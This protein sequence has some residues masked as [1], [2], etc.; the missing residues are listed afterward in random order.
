MTNSVD[1]TQLELDRIKNELETLKEISELVTSSIDFNKLLINIINTIARKMQTDICSVYLLDNDNS[2]VLEAT[3]G[4]NHEVVGKLKLKIGE[5]IIGYTAESGEPCMVARSEHHP[6]YVYCPETGE[7][8]DYSMLAVPLRREGLIMGVLCVQTYHERIYN[9]D[10]VNF[11]FTTA[12][13]ISG[14]I[15]NAQLF[16]NQK[17][18]LEEISHLYEVGN[19][20]SHSLELPTVLSQI[21]TICA[22]MVDARGSILQLKDRGHHYETLKYVHGTARNPEFK[23]V[24]E[25]ISPY[26][27]DV[28]HQG[29]NLLLQEGRQGSTEFGLFVSP[30]SLV[31]VPIILKG[32]VIGT[33]IV[34]DK[35]HI[36]NQFTTDDERL[37]SILSSQAAIYIQNAR[38]FDMIRKNEQQLIEIRE[39][40]L[41]SERL[42]AI[43]EMSARV[44]H[45]IRN[46]LVAIGGFARKAYEQSPEEGKGKQYL[47]IVIDEVNRLERILYDILDLSSPA[48]L[49]YQI[50]NLHEMLEES[51]LMVKE[52]CKAKN[53][54]I[55]ARYDANQ[56]LIKADRGQIK[57]VFL[58]LFQN[59]LESMEKTGGDLKIHTYT[60]PHERGKPERIVVTVRDTGC[61]IPQKDQPHIFDPF[62]SSKPKGSGL[63]LPITHKILMAHQAT[64][65]LVSRIN[66]G[67]MFIIEFPLHLTPT[68]E[69]ND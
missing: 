26:I 43:G 4:L 16:E 42:A 64:I 57:Q 65:S 25:Q 62:F 41:R 20:L 49:R 28:L 10:E 19:L 40:L 47:A 5:G 68:G 31:G 63:G 39:Q 51:I 21:V 1:I 24:L 32:D 30:V 37:L 18:S 66:L 15:R 44:A 22:E 60:S 11:L 7:H 6:R 3:I 8:G 14:A 38:L 48:Q 69:K 50:I 9:S 33:I 29:K 67:T 52:I 12:S 53:V 17:K 27:Q 23:L 2:L 45:E 34:F 54:I 59:A 58:N 13:Q 56:F 35:N 61:G 46:P 55:Q 36:D